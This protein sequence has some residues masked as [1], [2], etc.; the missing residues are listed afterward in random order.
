M[1]RGSKTLLSPDTGQALLHSPQVKQ[2]ADRV[3]AADF[4]NI[5]PPGR[6]P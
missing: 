4:P 6:T 2:A 3:A 5:E 1:N